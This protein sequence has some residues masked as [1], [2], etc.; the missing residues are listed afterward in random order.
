MASEPDWKH[1]LLAYIELVVQNEGVT[2]LPDEFDGSDKRVRALSTE[3]AAALYEAAAE[4]FPDSDF[5]KE[6]TAEVNRL[7][8]SLRR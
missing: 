2:F 4:L 6:M 7:R 1:I 8:D 3:E 5:Q